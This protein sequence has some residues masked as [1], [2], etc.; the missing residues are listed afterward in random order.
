M[1]PRRAIPKNPQSPPSRSRVPGATSGTR[2]ELSPLK[3]CSRA[4]RPLSLSLLAGCST[5]P[6]ALSLVIA[7]Y[8]WPGGP[9]EPVTRVAW[10]QAKPGDTRLLH[11]PKFPAVVSI[12]VTGLGRVSCPNSQAGMMLRSSGTLWACRSGSQPHRQVGRGTRAPDP[13]DRSLIWT[14]PI[15]RAW[16]SQAA[17][18]A[19]AASYLCRGHRAPTGRQNCMEQMPGWEHPFSEPKGLRA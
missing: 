18:P 4:P 12:A 19:Q 14:G 13:C 15:L 16:P 5:R 10:Q 7:D 1:P 3:Q 11:T 2:G 9:G 8:P 17:S 6:S